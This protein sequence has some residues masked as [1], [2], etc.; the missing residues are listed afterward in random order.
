M[1]SD[2]MGRYAFDGAEGYAFHIYEDD[3][4]E[5]LLT[6]VRFDELEE[7]GAFLKHNLPGLFDEPDYEY[8]TRVP[9]SEEAHGPGVYKYE[10]HPSEQ[11]ARDDVQDRDDYFADVR[12]EGSTWPK[13]EVV[14]RVRAG[15]WEVVS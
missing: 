11:D 14:R 15:Q 5:T 1:V 4:Q 2:T 8:G 13:M 10:A 6:T 7:F 12:P 9:L 3:T